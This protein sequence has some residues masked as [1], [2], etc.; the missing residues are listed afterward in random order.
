MAAQKVRG[1]STYCEIKDVSI[2]QQEALVKVLLFSNEENKVTF[3]LRFYLLDIETNKRELINNNF[4]WVE[5]FQTSLVGLD[6]IQNNVDVNL[7]KEILFKVDITNKNRATFKVNRWI[8][9]VRILIIVEK[10]FGLSNQ[11]QEGDV[12]YTS[13]LLNLV[14]GL[15]VIPD[16]K[17]IDIKSV[18]LNNDSNIEEII[19]RAF[20]DYGI[21]NDFNY[22]NQN[23]QYHFRII[24]PRTLKTINR[25]VLI[26]NGESDESSKLG[27]LK[28]TFS[29]MSLRKP[30]LVN[31][32]I[33][34]LKGF[35]IKDYTRLYIPQ[36]PKNKM[37]VKFNGLVKEVTS[38]FS[39]FVGEG[40]ANIDNLY[41]NTN[42]VDVKHN[43][44]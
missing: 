38:I 4:Y 33:R 28:Y 18:N 24:N 19:V 10:I 16:I 23:I 6:A 14:S 31:I 39:N 43:N 2:T 42:G 15:V 32:S 35:I 1:L 41:S 21:E 8:R 40:S 44:N 25:R 11:V 12:V 13:E 7:Y 22:S 26:E 34:D 9:P 20:Y 17:A 3:G 36:V 30:I 27:V 29:G 37:F 5:R